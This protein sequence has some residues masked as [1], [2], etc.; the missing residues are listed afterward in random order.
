[1]KYKLVFSIFFIG[2][3]VILIS[4][5][6]LGRV[7]YTLKYDEFISKYS[8]EYSLDPFMVASLIK[9]ESN[10]DSNAKSHRDAYGLMQITAETGKWAAGEMKIENFNS[11][12]LYDPEFNIKMGCW[13]LSKLKRQ[14]NGNMNVV[15]AAYN[16]G[17]GNVQKWL[18]S[19]KHSSDGQNLDYIPFKETDK[20]VK[21]V[22]TNIKI[23]KFLY[24]GIK[25]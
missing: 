6:P 25:K 18:N 14:F 12:L 11:D 9:A 23:Y 4:I 13:Y 21:R 22:N 19:T 3:V 7:F 20:Y 24:I 1:M 17:S 16:G 8:M 15:L 2:L 5:K 10:F